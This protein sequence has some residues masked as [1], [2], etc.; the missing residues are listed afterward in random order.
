MLV[1]ILVRGT[2]DFPSTEYEEYCC[3][4]VR[5]K[6]RNTDIYFA[7]EILRVCTLEDKAIILKHEEYG[8]R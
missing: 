2:A 8:V 7:Y 6:A 1:R 3:G 4:G 5:I